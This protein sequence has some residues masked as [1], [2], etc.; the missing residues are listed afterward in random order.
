MLGIRGAWRHVSWGGTAEQAGYGS[1]F[2][3][4]AARLRRHFQCDADF[5]RFPAQFVDSANQF[6]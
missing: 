6:L 4:I 2:R 3:I 5:A 1:T